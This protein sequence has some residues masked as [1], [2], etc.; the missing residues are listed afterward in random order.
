MPEALQ[1][2]MQSPGEIALGEAYA[3]GKLDV[4]G[5]LYAAFDAVEYLL[6]APM[7]L[8]SRFLQQLSRCSF[9]LA[10][11]V[12]R[13]YRHS[14]RRDASSISYHYDLPVAF[15]ESWLGPTLLYSAAYFR[16]SSNGLDEAQKNKLDLICRK[17]DLRR[18]DQFIDIGCGWGT[19]AI[20]A[21]SAYG[22]QTRGI[23]ISQQQARAAA[24][25]IADAHLNG[26]CFIENRDYRD[27]L[28]LPYRFDK[29]ASIG[30]FEHVG[31]RRLRKYF[32]VVHGL[33]NPGGL[34]LNSGIVRSSSSPRRTHSF[35]DRY[36]FPDGELPT[37]PIALREA[38]AAGLEVRDVENLRE[39]YSRTLRLWVKNLQEQAPRLS[40]LVSERTLR[41]WLLYMTGSA[42][43]FERGDI[44][45]C[46]ILLQRPEPGKRTE[47]CTREKWYK[48]R[49]RASSPLA[50]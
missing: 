31:L 39:H 25:R 5:D 45:V 17:L 4:D 35:I 49:E 48:T 12:F 24:R 9:T 20:H 33:L 30:M 43:A 42:V 38:E 36:V 22:A 47:I 23:T 41:I 46:Q 27:A 1:A 2:L 16:D 26:S 28:Q 29:A 34:F 19:L 14:Q 32:T 8:R 15:Y 3:S 18:G 11:S 40:Q 50:A 13:G 6:A 37:L 7:R 10:D 21:T 44:S